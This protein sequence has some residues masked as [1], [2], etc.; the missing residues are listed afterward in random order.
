M[1]HVD[2][3]GVERIGRPNEAVPGTMKKRAQTGTL[4][5]HAEMVRKKGNK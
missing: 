1:V 3:D 2:R 5:K 4:F